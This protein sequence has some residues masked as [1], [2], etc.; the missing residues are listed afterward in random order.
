M[1]LISTFLPIL[2]VSAYNSKWYN[3]NPVLQKCIEDYKTK[4]G[5]DNI[6]HKQAARITKCLAKQVSSPLKRILKDSKGKKCFKNFYKKNWSMELMTCVQNA[7]R[8][9]NWCGASFMSKDNVEYF[10]ME[11]EHWYYDETFCI[12][13]NIEALWGQKKYDKKVKLGVVVEEII[14]ACIEPAYIDLKSRKGLTKLIERNCRPD[15]ID[16]D[17]HDEFHY[18]D[19]EGMCVAFE[20]VCPNGTPSKPD[21]YPS[22][23]GYGG[24]G[25]YGDYGGNMDYQAG[26]TFNGEFK[27]KPDSCKSGWHGDKC[28]QVNECYCHNGEKSDR[29]YKNNYS[30]CVSCDKGFHLNEIGDYV[31]DYDRYCEPNECECEEGYPPQKTKDCPIAKGHYCDKCWDKK[32][33]KFEEF[34]GY[35]DF[36]N[37]YSHGQRKCVLTERGEEQYH[38]NF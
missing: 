27:C 6:D 20:C 29:C 32:N 38:Y 28:D 31:Y 34:N 4:V 9:E 25:G 24:Y 26:C 17:C 8:H 19:N 10:W 2:S 14:D 11:R 16:D 37:E 30:M 22:D 3:E 13:K 7:A 12:L 1:K 33:W 23:G 21:E 36:T 35:D 5:Q 18:N 15:G